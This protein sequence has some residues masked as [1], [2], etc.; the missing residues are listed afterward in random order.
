M[1]ARHVRF[2][3]P[4]PAKASFTHT[5]TGARRSVA[6][7]SAA[8][9]AEGRRRWRALALSVK[10][11]L[12]MVASGIVDFEDE[13]LSYIVMPDGKTVAEHVRPGIEEAYAGGKVKA[14][15]P[16]F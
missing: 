2:I 14:L 3:L 7:A 1:K 12:E 15:L 8:Y 11:K 5:K 13:F 9:E 16:A 4:M 6:S 10:A